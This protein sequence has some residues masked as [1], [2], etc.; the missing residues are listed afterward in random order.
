M[1]M[2]RGK[3]HHHVL[4]RLSSVSDW[5]TE[6]PSETMAAERVGRLRL[7]LDFEL[8]IRG[9]DDGGPDDGNRTRVFRPLSAGVHPA[10]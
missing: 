4:F 9:A 10:R 5:Q 3:S 6:P 7:R 1:I 2:V 8:V